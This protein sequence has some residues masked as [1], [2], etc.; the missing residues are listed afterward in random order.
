MV[1][2]QIYLATV[3][4]ERNRWD[5]RIPSLRVSDWSSRIAEA[6]FDGI[7]LWENHLLL[8]DG[9]ERDAVKRGPAP[10]VVLNTYCGFEAAAE[11]ARR[12]SAELARFLHVRAVKFNFGSDIDAVPEYI[13]NLAAWSELLPSGC[14]LL[15]ECHPGTVLEEPAA[16]ARLL[17]PSKCTVEVI[18][19]ALHGDDDSRLEAWLDVFSEQVTHVHAV[20]RDRDVA[21]RRIRFLKDVGFSGTWTVEFCKGVNEPGEDTDRLFAQARDDLAFLRSELA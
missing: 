11:D 17:A 10:V 5:S 14:R 15:C 21:R 12:Q 1:E 18:V 20:I 9:R 6:G 16:A 4:L 2:P 3:L 8:A 19:H 7:E 13:E